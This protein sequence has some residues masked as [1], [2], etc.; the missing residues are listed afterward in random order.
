MR[1]LVAMTS[2]SRI[3]SPSSLARPVVGVAPTSTR[4]LNGPRWAPKFTHPLGT[5]S[6]PFALCM[7]QR[8]ARI[9]NDCRAGVSGRH[10]WAARLFRRLGL[11]ASPE[12]AMI[13]KESLIVINVL[14]PTAFSGRGSLIVLEF[15]DEESA[16]K[17]AGKIAEET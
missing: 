6:S 9:C 7:P 3:Y 13:Q 15:S 8:F 2:A 16:L 12:P 17:L 5:K 10:L 14:N 11:N 1:P 4:S